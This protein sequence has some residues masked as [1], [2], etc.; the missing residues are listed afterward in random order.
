VPRG[1]LFW[2]ARVLGFIITLALLTYGLPHIDWPALYGALL[3]LD[4]GLIPLSIAATFLSYVLRTL[5]WR[6]ILR[7]YRPLGL[8]PLYSA[9]MIGFAANNLLPARAGEVVRALLLHQ[10]TGVSRSLVLSTVLLER[11][12]DGL[13]LIGMLGI[14]A[15]VWTVPGAGAAASLIV[16]ATFLVAIALV[17]VVAR[18]ERLAAWFATTAVRIAPARIKDVIGAKARSAL[19]G[20][21]VLR[22]RRGIIV[23]VALSLVVWGCEA[24]S[25]YALI[26][27][28]LGGQALPAALLATVTINLGIM[29]PAAP[30]Y[31]GTFEAA[32]ILALTNFGLSVADALAIALVSHGIQW[33]LVTG[34]GAAIALRAGYS[35]RPTR[36][37]PA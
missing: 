31:V 4:A 1:S 28:A 11:I 18:E 26:Q 34:I 17:T 30:G 35:L 3:D 10:E 27:S 8:G 7:P 33:M 21:A 9:L 12:F 19:E 29:L 15:L 5:R 23:V 16:A 25:Y 20:L 32:A 14:I 36:A 6:E 22:D 2:R 37:A 24:L 13:T